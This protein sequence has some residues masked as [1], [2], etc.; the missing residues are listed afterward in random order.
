MNCADRIGALDR[1][2]DRELPRVIRHSIGNKSTFLILHLHNGL[3]NATQ[4]L[5]LD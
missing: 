4:I 5:I 1:H 2:R 3:R